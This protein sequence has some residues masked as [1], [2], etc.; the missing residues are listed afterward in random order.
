MSTPV[1]QPTAATRKG[2]LASWWRRSA[3]QMRERPALSCL[4]LLVLIG[5]AATAGYFLHQHFEARRHWQ[6]AQRLIADSEFREA[7]PHLEACFAVWNH[8]GEAAFTL[9]RTCRRAGD[10]PA[11]KKYLKEAERLEWPED[12]LSFEYA[13]LRL[14]QEGAAPADE[15]FVQ[16]L[17]EKRSPEEVLLLEALCT[18][19]FRQ[20]QH[21]LTEQFLHHWVQN[22]PADWLPRF[23]RGHYFMTIGN[24]NQ[25]QTDLEKALELKPGHS[26][27]QALLVQALL[28]NGNPRRAMPLAEEFLQKHPDQTDILVALGKCQRTAQQFDAARATLQRALAKQKNHGGALLVLAQ[29]ENNQEN[30]REALR[31]LRE[32]DR[33]VLNDNEEINTAAAL[34]LNVLR[35]LGMHQEAEAAERRLEQLNQDLQEYRELMEELKK[36]PPTVTDRLRLGE[37]ALRIGVEDQALHWLDPVARE[38]P[39]ERRKVQEMMLEFYEKRDD[40]MSRERAEVLR[41][42]LGVPP[43]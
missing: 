43:R 25:A 26:E 36:R 30:P 24:T 4:I 38:V 35:R 18:G 21:R 5:V 20:S 41:R 28:K 31:W 9:A 15:A 8:S 42:Q 33:A 12:Q 19:L 10:I 39:A 7:R 14:Q 6:E 32:L 27:A 34:R 29:I 1:Q 3:A 22:Y 23:W 37:L 11:A 13:L 17:L 16:R 40:P 2:A